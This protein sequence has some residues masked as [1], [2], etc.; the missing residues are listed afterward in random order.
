[1]SYMQ[2]YLVEK[3]HQKKKV[4]ECLVL[5]IRQLGV[6][7]NTP[8]T[9]DFPQIPKGNVKFTCYKGEVSRNILPYT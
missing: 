6:V 7:D 5:I 9:Q 4:V 1:M 8:T 2:R 3:C